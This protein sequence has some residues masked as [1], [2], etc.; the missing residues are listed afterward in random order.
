RSIVYHEPAGVDLYRRLGDPPLDRL[1]VGEALAERHA[2][3]GVLDHHV[4]RAACHADAP[5]ADLQAPYRQAQLH[6]REASAFLAE[7]LRRG[8]AAVVEGQLVGA[9]TAEHRDFALDV[10]ALGAALDDERGD[11]F[12]ALALAGARHDDGEVRLRHAADPDLA[13]VDH[14]VPA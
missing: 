1:A 11:A 13:P 4:E 9:L 14:P 3:P 5:G 12:V 7:Q 8:D 6:R 10:E 2:L